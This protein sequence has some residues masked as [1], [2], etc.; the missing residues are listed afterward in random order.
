MKERIITG[1]VLTIFFLPLA[2]P[3]V[4]GSPF[5][6]ILFAVFAAIGT[7]EILRCLQLL[8]FYAISVPLIVLC[9][10][11]PLFAYCLPISLFVRG[12][13]AAALIL[14][15][16]VM[17]ITIW[18]KG[19]LRPLASVSAVTLTAYIACGFCSVILL[20]G[21]AHGAFLIYLV[22]LGAW[23]TDI[24]AY[25]TGMLF[26]KHKLIVDVSPK[27]TV[28][29]AIGGVLFTALSYLLFGVIL[30][31]FKEVDV[32][33]F[34]FFL[35]GICAAVVAQIGDLMFSL[36]KREYGIKDYGKIFP[37]HGGVL[38]RF[39]SFLA[40]APFVYLLCGLFA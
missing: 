13:L 3:V 23:V 22:F 40:V 28:E 18:S 4:S 11:T 31:H 38:D 14:Y 10:L 36:F 2:F 5:M 17:T 33:L 12:A 16:Y 9:G 20:R 30:S 15:F 24:F 27:K 1:A 37:G 32:S 19:K 29:G 8:R 6:C 21:E 25:F 26:G 35:I 34:S 39:D 7:L